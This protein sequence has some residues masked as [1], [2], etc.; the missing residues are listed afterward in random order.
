MTHQVQPKSPESATKVRELAPQELEQVNAGSGA[1]FAFADG[2][3][4]FVSSSSGL[5]RLYGDYNGDGDIDAADYV[6]WR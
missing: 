4:R 6:I 2:S 1:N 5:Y 3:V